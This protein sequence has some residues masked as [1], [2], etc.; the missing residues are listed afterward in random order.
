MYIYCFCFECIYLQHIL[1]IVNKYIQNK[2]NIYIYIYIYIFHTFVYIYIH[3]YT[4]VFI[5]IHYKMEKIKKELESIQ[6]NLKSIKN[7]SKQIK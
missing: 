3:L 4:F 5:C 1:Y 7:L 6:I 2:N